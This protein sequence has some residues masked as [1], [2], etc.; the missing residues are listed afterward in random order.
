VPVLRSRPRAERWEALRAGII[1]EGD[2]SE[3]EKEL[4]RKRGR[5]QR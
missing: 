5:E 3:D 2:G 4:R 1:A